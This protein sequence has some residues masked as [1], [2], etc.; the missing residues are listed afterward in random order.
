MWRACEAIN[1][2]VSKQAGIGNFLLITS[3]KTGYVQ[4]NP[5]YLETTIS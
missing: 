4:I 5:D 3:G 1:A 2:K